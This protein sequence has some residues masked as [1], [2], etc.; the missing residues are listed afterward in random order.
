VIFVDE[1]DRCA[2]HEVATTLETIKTFLEAKR[3]VFIV[4][5]DHQVLEQALRKQ[6]RQQTPHDITNPYYRPRVAVRTVIVRDQRAT[7]ARFHVSLCS[8]RRRFRAARATS[9]YCSS[10]ALRAAAGATHRS[11]A[12]QLPGP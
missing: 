11:A 12:P 3:C 8:R 2:P 10:A 6:A 7:R 4:A 1:L 5:A 9:D